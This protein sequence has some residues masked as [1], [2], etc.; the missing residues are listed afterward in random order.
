MLI[1]Q[2]DSHLREL[3]ILPNLTSGEKFYVAELQYAKGSIKLGAMICMDREF[4]ESAR[5]LS[6]KEAEL[7]IVPNSCPLA[8]DDMLGDARLA[9]FRA[10]AYQELVGVAMTNYPAPKN[11]GHSCAFDNLGKQIV[12]AD[13][14]EQMVIAEFNMEQLRKIRKEEWACRGQPARRTGAY[15]I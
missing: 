4:C 10:I 12:M 3:L 9:G 15:Q 1:G 14:R 6:L 8:T 13:D 7:I 5:T 2:G 11:D